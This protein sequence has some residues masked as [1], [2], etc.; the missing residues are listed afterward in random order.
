MSLRNS[1]QIN[2]YTCGVTAD[3]SNVEEEKE[4][5]GNNLKKIFKKKKNFKL[6]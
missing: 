1:T 2:T 4:S 5:G 3:L 6:F